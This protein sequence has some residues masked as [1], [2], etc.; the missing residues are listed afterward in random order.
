MLNSNLDDLIICNKC[1]FL[2]KKIMLSRNKVAKCK[3][4][5]YLMYRNTD[6]IFYKSVSYA[7]TALILFIVTN[8]FPIIKVYILGQ[9]GSLTILNMIY[10]LF[11]EEFYITGSI[12]LIVVIVAPLSV[13]I[14]YLSLAILVH[15]KLFKDLSKHIILFLI[16]SRNWAMVDIFA[17]SVLVALVKLSDYAQIEFDV[18]FVALFLFILVDIFVLKS[19]K[20]VELWAYFNKA[21]NEKKL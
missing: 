18:S 17:V 2:Q 16:I 20:P 15:F 9:E 1:G 3:N 4:C 5:G 19:I 14:S 11:K 21:Y 7:L 10:S 6:E 8:M 12:I 13:L